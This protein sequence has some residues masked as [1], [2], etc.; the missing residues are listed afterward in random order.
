MRVVHH[1]TIAA[2][3]LALPLA[4]SAHHSWRAVYDG[5]EE[6]TVE[7]TIVSEV[8]R[9]PHLTVQ[10]ELAGETGEPEKWTM[11][12]RGGRR[13]DGEPPVTYDINP[14]DEVVIEGRIAR[15]SGS[16]KIQMFALTRPAD[17]MSI[18]ARRGRNR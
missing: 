1:V 2:A 11:E 7:A 10:I 6:V 4:A 16:K 3:V 18:Q 13:R 12:W 17:G 15:F 5:G 9:N 8:Y 14:G